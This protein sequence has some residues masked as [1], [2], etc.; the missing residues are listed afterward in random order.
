MALGRL[1]LR[2][3]IFQVFLTEGSILFI[4]RLGLDKVFA[5][6]PCFFLSNFARWE[7]TGAIPTGNMLD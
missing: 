4:Q 2:E 3:A 5:T 1:F 7:Q 6:R